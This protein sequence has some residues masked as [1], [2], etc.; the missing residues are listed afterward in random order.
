MEC[1]SFEY[2]H[3]RLYPFSHFHGVLGHPQHTL[4]AIIII[5]I[6]NVERCL[7]SFD[8]G[9][10]NEYLGNLFH[11]IHLTFAYR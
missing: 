4:C 5:I 3:L 10:I 6:I 11:S 2:K 7:F 9:F 8:A 1:H